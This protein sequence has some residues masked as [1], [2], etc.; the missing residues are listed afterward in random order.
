MDALVVKHNV[1]ANASYS[2]S[3]TEQRLVLLAI[4]DARRSGQ[5]ITAND[6]LTIVASDYAKQFGTNRNTAY[7]ALKDSCAHLFER[8]FSCIEINKKGKREQIVSR[9]VSQISYVEDEAI[10]KLIFAP[11][12]V[13]LVTELEQHFTRYELEQVAGLSSAYAVRMYEILL[14]QRGRQKVDMIELSEL[15][16]RL[17]VEDG[18]YK[19]MHQLKARVLDMALSQINEHTDIT[20]KYKQHKSG[21]KI[22]GFSFNF[23]FKKTA[24]TPKKQPDPSYYTRAD[25]DK[26]PKLANPGESYEQ[27]LKR[28]NSQNKTLGT[29][30]EQTKLKL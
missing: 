23:S 3:L 24:S 9:W 25:L 26:N 30:E 5:G 20:A 17:G 11:A 16:N 29:E 13:P 4:I 22:I 8:R 10:V 6:P 7:Q 12:V 21:R 18:K 27:A 28:L 2:L 15:R 1:L 19:H 14:S